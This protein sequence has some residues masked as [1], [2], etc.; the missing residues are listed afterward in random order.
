MK[1]RKLVIENREKK[2]NMNEIFKKCNATNT[3]VAQWIHVSRVTLNI[4]KNTYYEHGTCTNQR[5]LHL[6]TRL[7][8][9]DNVTKSDL[10]LIINH[11]NFMFSNLEELLSIALSK[12]IK[13][14]S[15]VLSTINRFIDKGVDQEGWNDLV[16]DRELL[17]FAKRHGRFFDAKYDENIKW[18]G[19]IISMRKND[20]VELISKY[21]VA[22]KGMGKS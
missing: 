19:D 22:K 13:V 2:R 1:R 10:G 21:K 17:K 5:C 16:L 11:I 4:S 14:V 20:L 12:D 8:E 9:I 18:D 6:F 15:R 7:E 3:Q